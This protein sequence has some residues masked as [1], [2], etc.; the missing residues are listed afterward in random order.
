MIIPPPITKLEPLG[1]ILAERLAEERAKRPIL[2]PLWPNGE[3][4]YQ[5][6]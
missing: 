4:R 1:P 3:D 6:K 2:I 5:I